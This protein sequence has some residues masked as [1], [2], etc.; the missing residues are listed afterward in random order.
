MFGKVLFAFVIV[1]VAC[2]VATPIP[3]KDCGS[4]LLKITSLDGT[5]PFKKGVDLVINVNGTLLKD[6]TAGVFTLD[7]KLFGV[8]VFG[9]TGDLCLWSKTFTCPAGKGDHTISVTQAIPA[10]S[11][12]GQYDIVL[13]AT[14]QDKQPILCIDVLT[15]I[16]L[17]GEIVEAP[18]VT[19]AD[20]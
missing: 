16:S 3:Y 11:P 18:A 15:N 2:A 20:A 7:V 8:K 5:Y 4:P 12:S 13:K 9:Q 1:C 17:P 19:V 6:I 14:D 10:I